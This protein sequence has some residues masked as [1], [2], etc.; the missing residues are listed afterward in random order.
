M[1]TY[2]NQTYFY[3]S[4]LEDGNIVEN[5]YGLRISNNDKEYYIFDNNTRD[6][7][8]VDEKNYKHYVKNMSKNE[9]DIKRILLSGPDFLEPQSEKLQYTQR[10]PVRIEYDEVKALREENQY[11]RKMLYKYNAF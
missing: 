8:P 5:G 11:L 6:Y 1:S 9:Q 3:S 4:K 7:T 2:K 10:P